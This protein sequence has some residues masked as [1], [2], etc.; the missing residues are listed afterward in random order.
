MVLHV[1]FLF[2]TGAIKSKADPL[3][4]YEL[5][6]FLFQTGAIKRPIL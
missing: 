1:K 4:V 3:R 5:P 2:Q 6:Q